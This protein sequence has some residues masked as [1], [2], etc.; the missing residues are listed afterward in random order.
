MDRCKCGNVARH[1]GFNKEGGKIRFCCVCNVRA[2][3]PPA[4]WHP[5]CMREAGREK[6]T[7]VW[8]GESGTKRSSLI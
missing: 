1:T 4:E 7:V 8:H 5:E 3:N 6:E 2:G